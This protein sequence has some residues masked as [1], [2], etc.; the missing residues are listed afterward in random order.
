MST[1]AKIGTATI[2]Y[3]RMTIHTACRRCRGTGRE[4]QRIY[5]QKLEEIY[6]NHPQNKINRIKYVRAEWHLDLKSA[7]GLVEAFD[8]YKESTKVIEEKHATEMADANDELF[9][10]LAG[11]TYNLT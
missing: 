10:E 1:Q 4:D 9:G 11:F 8:K 5:I 6:N 7:K 2:E 3:D